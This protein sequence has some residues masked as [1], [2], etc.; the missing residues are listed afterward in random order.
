MGPKQCPDLGSAASG[1]AVHPG[2]GLPPPS[3]PKTR[4]PGPGCSHAHPQCV[5]APP[6]QS[7]TLLPPTL[8]PSCGPSCPSWSP[9]T[10]EKGN[11]VLR[12][13]YLVSWSY[14]KASSNTANPGPRSLPS[15]YDKGTCPQGEDPASPGSQPGRGSLASA[16][17]CL[18][19]SLP[20]VLRAQRCPARSKFTT[21]W[22]RPPWLPHQRR[23]AGYRE[24]GKA[25]G[26]VELGCPSWN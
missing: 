19:Q 4:A 20:L 12:C 26:W 3:H 14:R 21:Q 9:G 7:L 15:G 13:C 5:G 25:R 11:S 16:P 22:Q 1:P 10:C 24:D 18:Q 6:T 8:Q 17:A 2:G 23:A